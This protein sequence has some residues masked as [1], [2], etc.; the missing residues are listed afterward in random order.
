MADKLSGIGTNSLA[1]FRLNLPGTTDRF[2]NVRY[3]NVPSGPYVPFPSQQ[4]GTTD[5][6]GN[7]LF[8]PGQF[9]PPPQSQSFTPQQ[10]ALLDQGV[11]R[12]LLLAA[13]LK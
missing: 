3:D 5:Q 7:V 9:S 2:G 6:F 8:A 4:F 1:N 13:L 10:Q 11:P 12:N